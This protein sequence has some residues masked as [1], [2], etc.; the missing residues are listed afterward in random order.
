MHETPPERAE[1]HR[2]LEGLLFEYEHAGTALSELAALRR[3][4]QNLTGLILVSVMDA[5]D[6]G[7][8]WA[9]I[10]RAL[11]VSRQAVQK[12]FEALNH[13]EHDAPSLAP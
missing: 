4:R 7:D 11:G 10:G 13:G 12:M 6:H 9:Q 2:E 3:L 8:T 1:L 5:R